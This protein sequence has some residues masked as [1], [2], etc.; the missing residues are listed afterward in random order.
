MSRASAIREVV[1]V[2]FESLAAL[3]KVAPAEV[4][5]IV[6][7]M[8]AHLRA[9]RPESVSPLGTLPPPTGPIEPPTSPSRKAA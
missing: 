7:G 5:E 1:R 8:V 6:A 2:V 4:D 9:W 3:D